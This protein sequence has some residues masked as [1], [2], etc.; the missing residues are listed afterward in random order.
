MIMAS[1]SVEQFAG[2]QVLWVVHIGKDAIAAS[3]ALQEGFVCIGWTDIGDLSPYNTRDKMKAAMQKAYP[4]WSQNKINSCYGQTFRF[5]HE[6]KPRE[7][8]VYPIKGSTDIAIGRIA[9]PYRWASNDPQLVK[10][11]YANVRPVEWVRTVPRTEFSQAALH[12]FGSFS[13]V[14]RS[15]DY[16]EEVRSVLTGEATAPVTHTEV[17]P[18][19][20]DD[21]EPEHNLYESAL[22]ETEDYLLKGWQRTGAKFEEVVAAVFEALGYTSTVT[23]PSTDHGIDVIAHPDPLGL[24][25]PYIK[26]QVKS[27]TGSVGE[28]EVNQLKGLL[29]QGEQGILVSLGKFS[30]SAKAVERASPNVKLIGPKEFVRLFLEHYEQ[31]DPVWRSHFPLK[32]VYVPVR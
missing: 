27:G 29:H 6:M 15:D 25:K 18:V 26:V 32:R 5:A 14:T 20:Q 2:H 10:A 30:S 24:Q 8:L 12:S 16:L 19:D 23:P 7:P 28:P 31:L 1:T 21:V 17:P 4:S 11:D 9:G 3:R 13:S 22:Q